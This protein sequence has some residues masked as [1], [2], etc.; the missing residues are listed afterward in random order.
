MRF[1]VARRYVAG[2]MFD[3]LSCATD[4]RRSSPSRKPGILDKRCAMPRRRFAPTNG[5]EA[6]QLITYIR[7]VELSLA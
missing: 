2:P 6:D 3:I 7:R 5:D 1:K 4:A